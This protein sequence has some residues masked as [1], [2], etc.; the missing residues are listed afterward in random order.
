MRGQVKEA[1]GEGSSERLG[2]FV[3]ERSGSTGFQRRFRWCREVRFNRV[4]EKVPENVW[5]ALAQSQV[6]FNK[7]P[8]KVLEKIPEN[9]WEVLVQS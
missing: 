6:R 2:G 9:V 7:V 8:D 3:E 5:E 4:P 1:S